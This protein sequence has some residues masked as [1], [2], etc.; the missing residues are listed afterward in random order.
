MKL[1][2]RPVDAGFSDVQIL[3][4]ALP[5]L[6]IDEIDITC[7]FL[8]RKVDAPIIINAMTGGGGQAGAIN[9]VLARVAA[10]AGV[11][12][13]IGSQTVALNNPGE[14]ESFKIVRQENPQGVILANVGAEVTPDMAAQAVGMIGADGLQVHL[15][16]PQEL[17][18]AEGDRDFRGYLDN[19]HRIVETVAVPVIVKEVGFGLG[20]N[21]AAKL[22]QAGVQHIDVGG[23]GGTNFIAIE[24][25]RGQSCNLTY[26][27]SWGITTVCSIMEVASLQLPGTLIA[28]GGVR[29]PLDAV[30]AL[31]VGANMVGMAAPYLRVLMEDN[32]EG[33]YKEICD[34]KRQMAQIMLMAG[35]RDLAGLAKVP[36]VITGRTREWLNER[37]LDTKSVARRKNNVDDLIKPV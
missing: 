2:E 35:A 21:T 4:E 31:V 34:Y 3:H 29:N 16:V 32:R 33:L 28:T 5:E 24:Q 9:A 36:A 13:A 11:V 1:A 6:A 27:E 19:I 23:R 18:M 10:D 20:R 8:G 25:M 14:A 22:L 37:G 30:K 15:N 7:K 17:A 26:L 12:M